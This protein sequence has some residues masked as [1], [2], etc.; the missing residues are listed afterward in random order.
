[1]Y[2]SLLLNAGGGIIPRN[3]KSEQSKEAAVLAIGLGGTGVRAL[4][5]LKQSVYHQLRADNED[6]PGEP[7]KNYKHIQFLAI[8]S[9]DSDIRKIKGYPRLDSQNE[10]FS[11]HDENLKASLQD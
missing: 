7:I 1:M 10:F 3:Q 9:D 5:R 6:N 4:S 8:D 2:N 11:L